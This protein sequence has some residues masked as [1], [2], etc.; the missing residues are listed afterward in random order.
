M[1]EIPPEYKA[2]AEVLA[3]AITHLNDLDAAS[4]STMPRETWL[5]WTRAAKRIRIAPQE[6]QPAGRYIT[7]TPQQKL[8][9]VAGRLAA[10]VETLLTATSMESVVATLPPDFDTRMLADAIEIRDLLRHIYNMAVQS[11]E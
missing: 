8:N 6:P 10:N 2:S 1:S 11:G 4:I 7:L 5:E 9:N 3:S